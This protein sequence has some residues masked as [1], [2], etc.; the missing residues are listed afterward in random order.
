[1]SDSKGGQSTVDDTVVIRRVQ[2]SEAPAV[3]ELWNSMC[4]ETP[5]GGPLTAQG[6]RNITRMVEVSAWHH[7]TA[8]LVAVH[9]AV[10]VGFVMTR[11]DPGDGL[12]PC[13]A[14]QIE[15]LYV[16]PEARGRGIGRR[17][18]EQAVARL[19]ER[20]VWTI[21]NLVCAD[22]PA[23]HAFWRRLGFVADMVCLSLY[24]AA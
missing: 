16:V 18:A 3:A 9:D 22:D 10:V 24:R 17:L 8:C 19:R 23:A 4:R 14:G 11:V 13:L 6:I 15:E 21:R 2:E 1:M 12:L 5:D 7:E 20:D